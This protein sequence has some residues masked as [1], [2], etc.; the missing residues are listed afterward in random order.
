MTPMLFVT[1][2]PYPPAMTS[3]R[4][5]PWRELRDRPHITLAFDQI[6]DRFGG[7]LYGRRGDQAAVVI[8][9]ELDR[10][11]RRC[12]L[13]HELLHDER[14]VLAPDATAATMQIEERA[15]RR[16]AARRLVPLDELERFVTTRATVDMVTAEL[17]ADEFDVTI[18]VASEAIRQLQ[19]QLLERELR[20]STANP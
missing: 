19:A 9:P 11:G 4:W 13:G 16:E 15:V 8:S 18:T 1:P 10:A 12:A 20:R 14:G 7:G 2:P 5:H 17:V 6:A 3:R